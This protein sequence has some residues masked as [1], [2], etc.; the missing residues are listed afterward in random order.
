MDHTNFKVLFSDIGGVLL[1]NGWG[2]GSRE[3]AA[4]H[5]NID[6]EEM[7]TIHE[8]IFNVYEIGRMTL[9]EYLNTVVFNQPR[10]FTREDFKSFI[11]AQ[12]VE[13]PGLLQWLIEWKKANPQIRIISI[14]NEGK[15]L[16]D[17]R[18]KKFKLHGCFDAF[19]SSCEVGMRKP[20]PRIFQL[21]M[22]VAQT[23]PQQCY[24]FDDR[25]MLVEAANRVGMKAY[26]HT[27]FEVTKS[28]IE[29]IK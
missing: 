18:I 15:E 16:N 13:L 29:N 19:I 11:F 21:A 17:Y 8:F 3:K 22:G 1:S 7:N 2:R 12:S 6:F 20:D 25:I 9:D 10:E 23:S 27:S 24:Y 4:R 14:N 28:I 26:H 5:F